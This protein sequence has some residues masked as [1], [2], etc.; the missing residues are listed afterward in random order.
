VGSKSCIGSSAFE[1][2]QGTIGDESCTNPNACAGLKQT[3]NVG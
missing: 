2:A 1:N 3:A